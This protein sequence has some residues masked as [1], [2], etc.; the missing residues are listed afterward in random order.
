MSKKQDAC[1]VLSIFM[2]TLQFSFYEIVNAFVIIFSKLIN[3]IDYKCNK[4]TK[5]HFGPN[6]MHFFEAVLI[7]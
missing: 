5:W 3:D 2:V 4:K 7:V 1:H 6:C